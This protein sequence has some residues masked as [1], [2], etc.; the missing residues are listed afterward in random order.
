[1]VSALFIYFLLGR[2][3]APVSV[4]CRPLSVL[5]MFLLTLLFLYGHS[6]IVYDRQ[7]L[8]DIYHSMPK[9]FGFY[10]DLNS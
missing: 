8:I 9:P 6:L 4:A 3:M 7:Q 2:V 5:I 1:M 10:N